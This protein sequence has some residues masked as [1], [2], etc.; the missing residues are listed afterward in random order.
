MPFSKFQN[1]ISLFKVT[2]KGVIINIRIVQNP[3]TTD[4]PQLSILIKHIIYVQEM[5]SFKAVAY[6]D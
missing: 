1:S 5:N 6:L 3:Q 4:P 2:K